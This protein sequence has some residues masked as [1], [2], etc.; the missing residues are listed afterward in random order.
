MMQSNDV[1]W[2]EIFRTANDFIFIFFYITISKLK[3]RGKKKTSHSVL[4]HDLFFYLYQSFY[5]YFIILY[6][7]QEILN[8]IKEI[9]KFLKIKNS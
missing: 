3:I 6:N 9:N 7:L 4:L 5:S 8:I 2:K 1:E